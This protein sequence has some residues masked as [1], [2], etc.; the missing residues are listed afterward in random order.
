M[1]RTALATEA[2]YTATIIDAA[3][4][5]G[6]RTAHFRPARTVHGW[7]TAVQGDAKGWPD[8]VLVHP[9]AGYVW[10]VELKRDDAP[11]LRL[12]QD[13]WRLWLIGAGAVHY[14]VKVPSGLDGFIESLQ[15]AA[16]HPKP[17]TS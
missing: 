1:A 11:K 10:F 3:R 12:E 9:D 14:V 4:I 13:L 5:L 8:L 6:W 17:V 2:E 16:R 7:R 15:I